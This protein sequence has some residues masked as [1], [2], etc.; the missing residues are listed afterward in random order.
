M[1]YYE[2]PLKLISGVN[3]DLRKNIMEKGARSAQRYF[4]R[5]GLKGLDKKGV[6]R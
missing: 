1:E 2:E 3:E 6:M 4:M 5:K